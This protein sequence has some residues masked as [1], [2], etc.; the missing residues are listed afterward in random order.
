MLNSNKKLNK[1]AEEEIYF[2]Y[3]RTFS[4]WQDEIDDPYLLNLADQFTKSKLQAQLANIHANIYYSESNDLQECIKHALSSN[5]K[6]ALIQKPGHRVSHDTCFH[7]IEQA[8]SSP[9]TA[10][11][12]HIVDNDAKSRTHL[13]RNW[14]SIHPQ[15][16]FLNL[17]IYKDIHCPDLHTSFNLTTEELYEPERC[18][19]DFHDDYT[20]LW[21]KPRDYKLK[22]KEIEKGTRMGWGW[23]FLNAVFKYGY[24]VEGF[25]LKIRESKEFY[26]LDEVQ[27]DKELL[28]EMESKVRYQNSLTTRGYSSKLYAFNS[29]PYPTEMPNN[30]FYKLLEEINAPKQ[31]D[32]YVIL[33]A[34]FAGN[35]ILKTFNYSGKENVIFYDIS[36]PSLSF[37]RLLPEHWNPKKQTFK[38]IFNKLV[39]IKFTDNTNNQDSI[40]E[41]CDDIGEFDEL[42]KEEC[43]R[44]G[45]LE[46]F[47]QHWKTFVKNKQQHEYWRWDIL[48]NHEGWQVNKINKLTGN[49]FIWVSNVYANEFTLWEYKNYSNIFKQLKKLISNLNDRVHVY[50]FLPDIKLDDDDSEQIY[51]SFGRKIL[52]GKIHTKKFLQENIN[53]PTKSFCILPWIHMTSSVAGWYRVCCDS[54]KNLRGDNTKNLKDDANKDALHANLASIK[55]AFY[56]SEMDDIRKQFLNN[57]KPKI[58]S[59]CWKREDMGIASLRIAMNGRFADN[60]NSLNSKEP[61]L[62]Y[63]DIKYDNKCN[64]ACRMCSAG[65]S[66]QH[67]KELLIQVNDDKRIPNH[68]DYGRYAKNDRYKKQMSDRL[69]F[70]AEKPFLEQDVISAIPELEVLKVTGGEPTVNHKFLNA[71]DYAIKNDYAKNIVLDLTTNGTKFN[72]DLLEKISHF[73]YC[74]FRIS[75]DGTNKV[76][77]YIRYPFNWDALNKSVNL[78]FSHF[79]KKGTLENKV[80]IG[81]SI[82]AQPYNIF[83]LDD[84]YIWASNLYS[85]YYPGYAEWDDP[86]AMSEVDVDFQMIPQSSELNPEFID[87]DL[88]KL[89]L[90]KFEA[91]TKKVVGIIPRLEFFQ[92]FVKNIPV[93]NIKDLKHYQLKQTTRFYDNIRNQQYKNHL[94]PEMIDYLDNAP[95]APW[96]KEDS[97]FCILP[98]IHLSTRTTG[99]MQLCCTANSSSDEEHPQIGCN[100][101]NDGQLVNLKQDNW[102][103]YWNTNYMKNV[104]S[105][106][107]KG[108]KPRECQKCYKEE[109]VGYNSKRMW[110]NEKWKKKLDYNSIVWHTENDGTAPANIHYVDLKL[111]NKCNLA[112]STCNPD[113]SSFWIKDWKKMMN[114]DISSDLQDKLSWSKGKNQNGGYNWYKNEQTWKGLSNQPIS[115]AYILGGEPTIIDEFKHFIKNSPKTTNLRFNTNAEEIDDK[116]FP[117][118]RKLSLVEIAVSL[119]G[120]EKRHEWLRY[121]SK[122]DKTMQ[123]LIRYNRFATNNENIKINIDTT[124]SIFNIMHIPDFIKWKLAQDEISEINKWPQHGGMIGIH[125]LHSPNFLSV[126]C[127]TKEYKEKTSDIYNDFYKWLEENFEYYDQ[128]LERPNGIKKLKSLIEFMWSEDQSEL[129]PQT[130]EYI[131]NLE[132]IRQLNFSII[133]PELKE[134]YNEYR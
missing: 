133:F 101:K 88:L 45:G 77:D 5:R 97:G 103:D 96:K 116:L 49:T 71:V 51:N 91:N 6:Y 73:K 3:W 84:I 66:D 36:G 75:I 90:E 11:L 70:R 78:M 79:K 22:M 14:Y 72:T 7:L 74:R 50:G 52:K 43:V 12:C 23:N 18:V 39:N 34:G 62:K 107:L 24:N 56:S 13:K 31:F 86:D 30:N 53:I 81:F 89:A 126:K 125:F 119:D 26:Y 80:S 20:P 94:A 115:D 93:N 61:K 132:N 16:M 4:D 46:N 82:V 100:K 35:H 102:K 108:N 1:I 113:D 32:N 131:Q 122:L 112:C 60:I 134:L 33:S 106:M 104:R 29:E 114:N 68:F 123:N 38:D 127:L 111:G 47:V 2:C 109:E 21:L 98:W 128:V 55:D 41:F 19:E 69:S 57:E 65:S 92:N 17:E 37:K 48:N 28:N 25:N 27:Q 121:P 87:H 64:L 63:L 83:N 120:V 67:Q 8:E 40:I 118:L 15:M 9:N 130:F 95:K 76:Y 117:M 58:C 105:E 85:T 54:N 42:W 59:T 99:N 129:L 10:M 44:W 110:E 124:A